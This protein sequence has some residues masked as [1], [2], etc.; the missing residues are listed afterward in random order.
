MTVTIAIKLINCN[1]DKFL[2][3]FFFHSSSR[4]VG[5]CLLE[6][7]RATC[8]S[9][10]F[11]R[12]FFFSV[13][14]L[15]I[16]FIIQWYAR[17]VRH[18]IT[19]IAAHISN[20]MRWILSWLRMHAPEKHQHIQLSRILWHGKTQKCPKLISV[21]ISSNFWAGLAGWAAVETSSHRQPWVVR[22]RSS[23]L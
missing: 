17:N 10:S 12:T 14:K 7:R 19:V 4:Q 3:L 2:S 11:S 6:R 21:A 22:P 5:R 9:T 8:K 15:S 1:V 13:S 16:S 23:G 20:D 18:W